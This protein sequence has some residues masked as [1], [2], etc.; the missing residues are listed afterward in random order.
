MESSLTV[1]VKRLDRRDEPVELT[2][3]ADDNCKD[4]DCPAVYTTDRGSVVVQRYLVA[5]KTPAGEAVVEIPAELLAEA[6]R[7]L[8]G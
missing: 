8:G 6:F 1:L 5:H 4:G 2:K 3:I 7:A